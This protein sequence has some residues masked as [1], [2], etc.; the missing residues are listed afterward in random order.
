MRSWRTVVDVWQRLEEAKRVVGVTERLGDIVWLPD[1]DEDDEQDDEQ[2]QAEL[3]EA[4]AKHRS[5]L[6]R[7][8]GE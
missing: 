3:E 8:S 7:L 1:E 4:H 6:R 2:H 5:R